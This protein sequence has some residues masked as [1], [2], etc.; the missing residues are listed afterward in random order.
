M[1]ISIINWLDWEFVKIRCE[2]QS[3]KTVAEQGDAI[4]NQARA[5]LKLHGLTLSDTVRSRVFGVDRQARD[6]VSKSRF[7]AL[8]GND[9]AA[10]SS[11]IAPKHFASGALVALDLIA[12]RPRP[13]VAKIIKEYVPPKSPICYIALGP[14][15]VLSGN[16]SELPTLSEQISQDILPRIDSYL[17]EGGSGWKQV[18]NVSCYMHES[19]SPD[20]LRAHFKSTVDPFPARFEISFVEGFS[21]PGK[22][23]EVEVT[24]RRNG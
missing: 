1:K 11:Y 9:R 19:Q 10:S 4:F 5:A 13:G 14:L 6:A 17:T 8:K 18:V 20:E 21:S 22:L 15:L 16:T 24:A 2:A 3:G 7:E 12:V 23:V